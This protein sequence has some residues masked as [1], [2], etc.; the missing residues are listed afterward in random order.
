MQARMNFHPG[1]CFLLTAEGRVVAVCRDGWIG[2]VWKRD[3]L[4]VRDIST[5]LRGETLG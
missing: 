2:G 4:W 3:V 5:L 1:L